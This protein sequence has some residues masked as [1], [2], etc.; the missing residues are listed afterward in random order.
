MFYP[1]KEHHATHKHYQWILLTI[2]ILF[3]DKKQNKKHLSILFCFCFFNENF[4]IFT[5]RKLLLINLLFDL[6]MVYSFDF[7][8]L[9]KKIYWKWKYSHK[10]FFLPLHYLNINHINILSYFQVLKALFGFLVSSFFFISS[11]FFCCCCWFRFTWTSSSS[12]TTT[13]MIFEFYDSRK[14]TL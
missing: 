14:K 8:Y 2:D 5:K 3:A 9:G 12:S 7:A 4:K 11:H 13:N 1:F 6:I 10:D